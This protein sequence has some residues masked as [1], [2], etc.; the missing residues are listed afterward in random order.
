MGTILEETDRNRLMQSII[1][2]RFP[3]D[4]AEDRLGAKDLRKKL[5]RIRTAALQGL[6]ERT[7]GGGG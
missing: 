6:L 3:S 2:E 7:E 1:N 5:E 4:S